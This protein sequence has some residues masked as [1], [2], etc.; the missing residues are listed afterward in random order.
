MSF[1]NEITARINNSQ[2]K[3]FKAIFPGESNHYDTL[4]GGVALQ[5]M[6]EVAFITATR[7]TRKKVV[8][9]SSDKVN[10]KHPIPTGSLVELDAKVVR[11]GNTSLDVAVNVYRED[12]YADERILALHGKFTFVTV[13]KQKV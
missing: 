1:D 3:T 11:V 5:W 4:F 7:F 6:D 13:N 2:T 8:T 10:F 9:I 12:M